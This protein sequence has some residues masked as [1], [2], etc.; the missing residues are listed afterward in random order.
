MKVI[1]GLT[2]AVDKGLFKKGCVLTIGNFDGFHTAHKQL[3]RQTIRIARQKRVPS[4]LMTFHPHPRNF[5]AKEETLPRLMRFREKWLALQTESLDYLVCLRFNQ[6]LA[7]LPAVDFVNQLL[8][9]QLN[10]KAVVV[11][12]DFSFG[13][14]R[15]GDFALLKQLGEQYGFDAYQM[16]AV[17]LNGQ[18]VS[19][20]Q[21]RFALAHGD[22]E[23]A[24]KLL[25]Q[26]YSLYG[27]VI[28]GDQRGRQWGFP[29]ANI[30]LYRTL[31]PLTGIYAVRI[32]G[33]DF[34]ANGVAS[35]GFR[36][37][38]KVTQPLLEVHILDFDRDL[39]G[40]HLRVQFLHF[41]RDESDFSS[42]DSLIAQ[43]NADVDSARAYFSNHY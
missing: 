43:I 14:S 24:T 25:G 5:F 32:L 3:I 31:P 1:R 42:V 2:Y 6:A 17:L 40:Q 30:P 29:T 10:S 26:P 37:V 36:P 8:V 27:P 38:F 22:C 21:V 13:A 18:R 39:Y 28:R 20:R 41:I 11:G 9:D 33:P 7:T 12:D 19:S 4:V 35:I 15:L 16:K 23:Q 34:I